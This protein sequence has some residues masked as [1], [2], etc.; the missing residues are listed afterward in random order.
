MPK[1]NQCGNTK[2]FWA[3]ASM[4]SLVEYDD[5][6]AIK[7]IRAKK[8]QPQD[9]GSLTFLSMQCQACSSLD[10]D[11]SHKAN[12]SERVAMVSCPLCGYRLRLRGVN[13]GKK[14]KVNCSHCNKPFVTVA[15]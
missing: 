9:F 3:F 6:G 15:P 10:V 4:E 5:F 7:E 2:Q 11:Q 13:P 14:L 12:Q 1:C 8:V